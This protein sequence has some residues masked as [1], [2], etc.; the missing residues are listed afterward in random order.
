[1]NRLIEAQID[2]PVAYFTRLVNAVAKKKV[3]I[4]PESAIG[5]NG[6]ITWKISRGGQRF[7]TF[8]IDQDIFNS[9]LQYIPGI[10]VGG[11]LSQSSATDPKWTSVVAFLLRI[12]AGSADP[13]HTTEDL[14]SV[15]AGDLNVKQLFEKFYQLV[16]Q[17]PGL[18]SA[19]NDVR[20]PSIEGLGSFLKKKGVDLGGGLSNTADAAPVGGTWGIL[21]HPKI[22]EAEAKF[23]AYPKDYESA[24]AKGEWV[25][26]APKNAKASMLFGGN[27]LYGTTGAAETAKYDPQLTKW[28]TASIAHSRWGG[29]TDRPIYIF[30]RKAPNQKKGRNDSESYSFGYY[31]WQNNFGNKG[32]TQVTKGTDDENDDPT[33]FYTEVVK[34]CK[35][36]VRNGVFEDYKNYYSKK[37]TVPKSKELMLFCKEAE[38]EWNKPLTNIEGALEFYGIEDFKIDHEAKTIQILGDYVYTEGE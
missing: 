21:K 25:V 1:M 33:E 10:Q 18:L 14:A 6:V 3:K 29:Y 27:G 32:M 34:D 36:D 30:L 12:I 16:D 38:A 2:S 23:N 5:E 31:R 4:F 22:D 13:I 17:N 9:I 24:L 28:C 20:P 15:G 26:I 35:D 11:T 19:L 8:K 7:D 37:G